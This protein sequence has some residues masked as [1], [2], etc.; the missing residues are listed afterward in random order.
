M[1]T[2]SDA[3]LT[4][5]CAVPSQRSWSGCALLGPVMSPGEAIFRMPRGSGLRR[6]LADG[7]F[8]PPQKWKLAIYSECNFDPKG[9]PR[10]PVSHNL[11]TRALDGLFG[12]TARIRYSVL[13]NHRGCRGPQG[14]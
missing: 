13:F 12:R 4:E 3:L 5:S 7:D 8:S 1:P 14:C 11:A 10:V 9:L 6:L 2:Y